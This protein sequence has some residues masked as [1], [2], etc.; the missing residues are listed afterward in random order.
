[1]RIAILMVLV[2]GSVTA[3]GGGGATVQ[4]GP[5]CGQ[6]LSDLK[7]AYDRGALSQKDYER[8]RSSAIK[9]CGRQR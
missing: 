7:D 8:L 1:M 4:A 6:E 3:C 5:T 9:R 2:I